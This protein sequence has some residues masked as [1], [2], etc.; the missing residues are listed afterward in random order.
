MNDPSVILSS[1]VGHFLE[2]PLDGGLI[3]DLLLDPA[4]TPEPEVEHSTTTT[5]ASATSLTGTTAATTTDN[6]DSSSSTTAN[7]IDLS[8][9]SP[10]ALGVLY[11]FGAKAAAF[12]VNVKVSAS[13]ATLHDLP[14]PINLM[15]WNNNSRM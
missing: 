6:K 12:A 9:I 1:L 11:A 3:K 14:F 13:V 8:G 4:S 5:I 15:S 10:G 7:G 2:S